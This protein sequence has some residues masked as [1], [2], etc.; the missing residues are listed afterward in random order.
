MDVQVFGHRKSADTRA[1]LRFFAERRIRV[2]F[3]DFEVRGP[4]AGELRRF[5]QQLGLDA[6]LDREGGRFA[7][8]GLR[9]AA[10][11]PE[12]WLE[13]LAEDPW[14]LRVPLVRWQQR[15]TVGRDEA[16]WRRWHDEARTR[17]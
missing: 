17:G 13:L 14:L 9:A 11:S 10:H 7:S 1:A 15:L 5:V 4:A 16:A 12:R 6:L 3:V 8:R 2:H